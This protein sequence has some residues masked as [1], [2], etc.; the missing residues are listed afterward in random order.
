MSKIVII[1]DNELIAKLYETNLIAE[2]H[3]V[4][5]IFDG[6]SG[7]KLIKELKPDIVLLDLMIPQM[8]GIEIIKQLRKE[9]E[10]ANLLILAYSGGDEEVL[11]AAREAG[12]SSIISKR[13]SSLKE[14]LRHLNELL[15]STGNL[16]PTISVSDK[17]INEIDKQK[18]EVSPSN[19]R[20]LIVEDDLLIVAI[21]K[22]IIEKA[23]YQTVV[24][25][26]GREAYRILTKDADFAAG[27]FDVHVPYIEGPDLLRHMRTEKRLMNIPVI[28]MTTEGSI[29]IQ[30]DSLSSGAAVFIQKPFERR[31]FE[32]I[33]TGLVG[34]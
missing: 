33:F 31:S 16:Q 9:A 19:K 2:G 25:G 26:D 7:F 14:I 15:L 24:A 32:A 12:A 28:I 13:E 1:E 8:S 29:K 6:A 17:I 34:N 23:G 21:V 4:K 11:N 20:V 5:V 3:T 22:N 18:T 27:I 10:F 30:L